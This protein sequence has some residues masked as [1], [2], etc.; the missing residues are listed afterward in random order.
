MSMALFDH[1]SGQHLEVGDA[2]IYHEVHGAA[3]AEPL[4][5]LHGGLGHMEDFN[6]LLPLVGEAWRVIGIDSRGHGKS[7]VGSEPLG[8]QRLQQDATAVLDHLGVSMTSAIGFSDG[9]IVAYRMAAERPARFRRLV[10][11]GSSSDA[12]QQPQTRALLGGMTADRW[13]AKFPGSE[14]SYRQLNPAPDFEALVR[15]AVSMWLDTGRSGYPGNAIEGINCPLLIVRGDDDHLV[16]LQQVVDTK[17]AVRGARLLNIPFA[18]HAVHEDPSAL[19]AEVLRR[20][21]AD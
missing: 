11:I 9:G 21:L 7:T 6:V 17:Q 13:K 18:G 15:A 4:L 5:F 1:L 10:T 20:F 2:L 16:S 3:G 12:P 8:Y 14:A 19:L